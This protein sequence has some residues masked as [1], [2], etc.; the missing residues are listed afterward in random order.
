MLEE[1]YIGN[2]GSNWGWLPEVYPK[3]YPDCH[4]NRGGVL[5]PIVSFILDKIW[6]NLKTNDYCPINLQPWCPALREA[7]KQKSSVRGRT[8]PP[9]LFLEV[10]EPLRHHSIL[11][12]KMEKKT[13]PSKNTQN[14]YIRYIFFL[15]GSAKNYPKPSIFKKKSISFRHKNGPQSYELA[16][17]PPPPL[18]K[19]SMTN[20]FFSPRWLP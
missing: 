11:V 18:W 1:R 6:N 5:Y 17:T 16:E 12:T 4:T 10:K 19:N 14:G 20:P 3:V 7:I 8:S 9:P 2:P 13:K 15:M